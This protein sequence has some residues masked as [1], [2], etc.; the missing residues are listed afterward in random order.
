MP[1][2]EVAF[3]DIGYFSQQETSIVQ[4]P[5][6]RGLLLPIAEMHIAMADLI[7]KLFVTTCVIKLLEGSKLK[8][9]DKVGKCFK[10]KNV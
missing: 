5:N 2:D 6:V 10:R 3:G 9:S 1:P 7:T 8:I 4:V